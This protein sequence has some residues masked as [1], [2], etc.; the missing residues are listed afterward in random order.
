[1]NLVTM[2]RVLQA[3]ALSLTAL[4]AVI[5]AQARGPASETHT[6]VVGGV[7]GP[8]LWTWDPAQ[9]TAAPGDRVRWENPSGVD[10]HV[11]PY[12]GPWQETLHLDSGGGTATVRVKKP[13]EYLYRCDV[14]GHSEVVGG[15][16]IGQ[17]GSITVE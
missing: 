13:G 4:A 10:H 3:L 14:Q 12:G 2:R 15:R 16:C 8:F 5:P 17:C 7:P 6:V 11:A 9:V 1:M